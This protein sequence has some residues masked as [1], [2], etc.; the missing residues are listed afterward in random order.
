[1]FLW[2]DVDSISEIHKYVRD[3]LVESDVQCPILSNEEGREVVAEDCEGKGG[4]DKHR[5]IKMAE[6]IL[7][8]D[9]QLVFAWTR[10][11]VGG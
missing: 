1:M 10:F 5:D 3:I 2:A 6:R 7:D 8:S 9:L 4:L 11:V